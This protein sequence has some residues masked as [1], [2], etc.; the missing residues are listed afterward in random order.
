MSLCVAEVFGSPTDQQGALT[1]ALASLSPPLSA[2]HSRAPT[3]QKS[4]FRRVAQLEALT[5]ALDHVTLL[6]ANGIA[7]NMSNS[8]HDTLLSRLVDGL[9][10][11][12]PLLD[13]AGVCPEHAPTHVIVNLEWTLLSADKLAP[14]KALIN[15]VHALIDRKFGDAQMRQRV[16][17]AIQGAEAA[18]PQDRAAVR[19]AL[20]DPDWMD[21]HD[22]ILFATPPQLLSLL[23]GMANQRYIC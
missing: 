20:F 16:F 7:L 14:A 10:E 2:P 9:P 12:A 8:L 21:E 19:T 18:E 13:S 5:S 17:V 11:G 4:Q 23:K 1:Q 6:Q 15:R 22:T 3:L